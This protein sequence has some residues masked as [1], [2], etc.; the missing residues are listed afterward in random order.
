MIL[1]GTQILKTQQSRP[2]SF[3]VLSQVIFT[4]VMKT[5]K[6]VYKGKSSV[7]C[8]NIHTL[9]SNK[10]LLLLQDSKEIVQQVKTHDVFVIG[11]LKVPS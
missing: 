11:I 4:N 6:E 1:L 9:S 7:I 10:H 5:N 3:F 8:T 2:K